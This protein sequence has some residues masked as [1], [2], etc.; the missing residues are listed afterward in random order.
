MT[1]QSTVSQQFAFVGGPVLKKEASNL[2]SSLVKR[3]LAQKRSQR[4]LDASNKLD[5]MLASKEDKSTDQCTCSPGAS[6]EKPWINSP[7]NTNQQPQLLPAQ[8]NCRL[9]GRPQPSPVG[10]QSYPNPT[11]L[12]AYRSNPFL[13]I[14]ATDAKLNVT[15]L[16]DFAA[17]T[18]WPQFRP[19]DY[20]GNGY[21]SWA[22]PM[23]DKVQLYAVLYAASYHRD[24]LRITYGA[25]DPI[26]DSKEQL[27]IRGLA[28]QTLRMEVAKLSEFA[29]PT[30]RLD[31]V[32]MCILYLAVNELH[33]GKMAR[34]CSLFTPPF[35]S[36]QALDVYGGRT[37]HPLHWNT[38]QELV[39]RSGGIEKI[40]TGRLTW[41]LS[42]SD[43]FG[44]FQVIRKPTYPMM[45]VAGRRLVLQRPAVLFQP[46]G[47]HTSTNLSPGLSTPGFGFQELSFMCPPVKQDIT[48][49]FIHLGEYSAVAQHCINTK[50]NVVLDLLGD[51]RNLIHNRLLSL[52][53]ETDP[54]ELIFEM[55]DSQTDTESEQSKLSLLL[56]HQIYHTCRLSALLYALHVTFPIPRFREP[57]LFILSALG[58]RIEWLRMRNVSQPVLIW[59]LAIL[60]SVLGDNAPEFE[61]LVSYMVPMA[62]EEAI[63]SVP[64]LLA[65]LHSFAWVDAAVGDHWRDLWERIFMS[66]ERGMEFAEC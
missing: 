7:R 19:V 30:T 64:T 32:I 18:I 53:D 63:D 38:M 39:Q 58:P 65:F 43:L 57:A 5:S 41:L 31:G 60:I 23:E 27:E 20:T 47:Y 55:P 24:A 34:D 9:C 15:E 13:P 36:M 52:P 2:R 45:T 61:G 48:E 26:L 29:S 28:L 4:W 12:G 21:R 22:F 14:D 35:I 42:L 6:V 17:T 59:C 37:Y 54:Y 56:S 51:S 16:L 44:A 40:A 62:R 8:L 49:A 10:P 25:E 1:Q 11:L 33:K 46:Y 66:V 50:S 3:A